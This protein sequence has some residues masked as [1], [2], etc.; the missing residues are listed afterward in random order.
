MLG[1]LAGLALVVVLVGLSAL[2]PH[3]RAVCFTLG[4]WLHSRSLR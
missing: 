2:Y 4:M 3:R 1:F